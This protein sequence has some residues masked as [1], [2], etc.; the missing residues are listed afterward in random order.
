MADNNNS[1]KKTTGQNGRGDYYSDKPIND[2]SNRNAKIILDEN[3]M[4]SAEDNIDTLLKG[5]IG[6]NLSSAIGNTFFGINHRQTPPPIQQNKEHH[7]LTFFT[8]PILNLTTGNV[9]AIRLLSPLLNRNENSLQRIIRTT[10]DSRLGRGSLNSNTEIGIK[11]PFV[12]PQQAFIP[13]LTNNLLSIS[14]WPDIMSNQFV[15]HPGAYKEEYSF[16][17]S[18]TTAYHSYD[19]TANFRN[20]PGDPVTLLFFAWV[21]YT[22]LVYQGLMMPYPDLLMENEIDYQTRIYRLVL[23]STKTRVVRIAACGAAYPVSV[24]I[25]ASFDFDHTKPYNDSHTQV[26]IPFKC[27]G[28]IYNDDILIDEFNRTVASFYVDMQDSRFS[29]SS[30]KRSNSRDAEDVQWVNSSLKE[31][32]IEA[33]GLFNNRGYPRINPETYKL[34][35]W[36][37]NDDYYRVMNGFKDNSDGSGRYLQKDIS[38]THVISDTPVTYPENV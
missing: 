16:V 15:S 3:G 14:G 31:I 25:G 6:N 36:I 20:I 34:E 7:G 8:R 19:I 33:L 23:D 12:D 21:H 13:F 29:A 5:T 1:I 26:T 9:R 11:C 22:S 28:A 37:S 2:V 27:V 18:V 38:G 35:W 30:S 10:L 17:D 4:G 24:P 32:P